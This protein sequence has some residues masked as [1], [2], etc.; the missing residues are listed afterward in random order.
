MALG[1]RQDRD[2]ASVIVYLRSLPPVHRQQPPTELIF[3]VRYLIRSAPEP[4][5][6]PVGE[7]DVSTPEKRG[8]Y[9]VTIAGCADCQTPQDAHG[10]PIAGLGLA[11]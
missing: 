5:D 4:L 7:P 8:K 10:Q 11:G 6:A 3:P 2:L 9:L 1:A